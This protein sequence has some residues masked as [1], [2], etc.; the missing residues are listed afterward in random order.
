MIAGGFGSAVL[1]HVSSTGAL[2]RIR[3]LGIPDEFQEHDGC[4]EILAR[5]G[6]TVDGIS[7]AVEEM[8]H[9]EA[10]GPWQ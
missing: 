2:A 9:A 3:V 6:L 7:N 8:V 10:A 1:E 4:G 5:L